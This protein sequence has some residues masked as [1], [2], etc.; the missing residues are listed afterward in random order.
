MPYMIHKL[1]LLFLSYLQ[2]FLSYDNKKLNLSVTYLHFWRSCY[3]HAKQVLSQIIAT[4]HLYQI[5][6]FLHIS[7]FLKLG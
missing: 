3:L 2:S 1:Y 4:S 6:L 7:M 5:Y